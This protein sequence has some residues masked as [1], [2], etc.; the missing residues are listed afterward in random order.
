MTAILKKFFSILS[1]TLT[2]ALATSVAYANAIAPV[3]GE[4]VTKMFDY[5][6]G[7]FIVVGADGY[8]YL[9]D[10]TLVA[11]S[12]LKLNDGKSLIAKYL[13]H[14]D[15]SG[16]KVKGRTS[17]SRLTGEKMAEVNDDWLYITYDFDPIT[18]YA[19]VNEGVAAMYVARDDGSDIDIGSIVA[20]IE[21]GR[22][23]AQTVNR[24]IIAKLAT[25]IYLDASYQIHLRGE[26]ANG[27]KIYLVLDGI[28]YRIFEGRLVNLDRS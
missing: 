7:N 24:T 1:L 14:V 28:T 3:E 12:W 23:G 6:S 2:F 27:D 19:P 16:E 18:G 25:G 21:Y 20:T 26:M 9:E 5:A 4:S 8:F 17:F 13:C 10:G 22:Y 15:E 11:N